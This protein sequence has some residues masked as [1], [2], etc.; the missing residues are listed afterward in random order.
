MQHI[1][2]TKYDKACKKILIGLLNHRRDLLD[3]LRDIDYERFEFV[4]ERLNL[5]YN[6]K[7][8]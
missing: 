8:P 4:L 2:T 1:V 7:W 5:V 3:R 6:V